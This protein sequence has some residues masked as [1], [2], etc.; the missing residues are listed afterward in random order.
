MSQQAREHPE[1]A[2]ETAEREIGIVRTGTVSV[3]GLC[4]ATLDE[5]AFVRKWIYDAASEGSQRTMLAEMRDLIAKN[6]RRNRVIIGS[7]LES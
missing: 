3:A 1:E 2:R 7:P 5:Q 4:G 6:P